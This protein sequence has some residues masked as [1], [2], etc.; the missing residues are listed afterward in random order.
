MYIAGLIF[1]VIGWAFQLYETLIKKTRNINVFLPVTYV[2]ACFLFGIN[3]LMAG[4]MLYAVMD[5]VCA[6]LALIVFLVLMTRK[7]NS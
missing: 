1:T 7:R 2:I 6:L 4:D 3:S 5:A